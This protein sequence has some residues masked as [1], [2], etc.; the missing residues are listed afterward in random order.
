MPHPATVYCFGHMIAKYQSRIAHQIK[1]KNV[2]HQQADDGGIISCSTA[3]TV[4]VDRG[5]K[6][7]RQQSQNNVQY[8]PRNDYGMN[9]RF[10]PQIQSDLDA[11]LIDIQEATRRSMRR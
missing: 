3:N 6:N 1:N 11:G 10:S 9:R 7:V 2:D 4:Y 8:R 5:N